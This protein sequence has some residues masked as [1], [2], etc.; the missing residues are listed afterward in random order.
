MSWMITASGAEVH[1]SGPKVATNRYEIDDVASAL[2]KINRFAGHT[3]RPYSVSEH[4]LLCADIAEQLGTSLHIQLAA[5]MHDGHEAFVGDCTSPVKERVGPAWSSFEN[6]VAHQFR[7]QFG[8]TP[9]FF[10]HK[11]A[12]RAID[13]MALATERRDLTNYSF[14]KPGSTP[15]PVLDTPGR[16]VAATHT[17]LCSLQREQRHWTEWRDLFLERY[18]YLVVSLIAANKSF[19]SG[20]VPRSK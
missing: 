7:S 20:L 9:T 1:F 14:G 2:A 18:D 17:N 4:S 16:E 12:I 15:W 3:K 10:T 19:G 6:G 8:L 11:G 13:L 5:L